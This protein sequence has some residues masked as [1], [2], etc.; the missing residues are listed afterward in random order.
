MV[1]GYGEYSNGYFKFGD[2]FIPFSSYNS[3]Y[4]K[5]NYSDEDIK[6]KNFIINAKYVGGFVPNK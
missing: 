2:S 1:W 6:S 5:T 4:E 3:P